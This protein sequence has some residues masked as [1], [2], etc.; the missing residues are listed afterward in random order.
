MQHN[1]TRK[2]HAGAYY[3]EYRS[4]VQTKLQMLMQQSL[5]KRNIK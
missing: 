2:T 1:V 4:P 5:A 3:A